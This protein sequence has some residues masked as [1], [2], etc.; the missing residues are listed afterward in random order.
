[1]LL[2]ELPAQQATSALRST[3]PAQTL[4]W[5]AVQAEQ[6]VN[7]LSLPL[8][9]PREPH[10]NSLLKEANHTNLTYRLNLI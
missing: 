5:L 1:M 9:L 10:L 3:N 2:R 4:M 6:D 7:T 8:G